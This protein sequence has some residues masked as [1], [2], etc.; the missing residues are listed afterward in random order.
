MAEALLCTI[1]ET[2][3]NSSLDTCR[4]YLILSLTPKRSVNRS[5]PTLQTFPSSF[6]GRWDV[7]NRGSSTF[8]EKPHCQGSRGRLRAHKLLDQQHTPVYFWSPWCLG[9]PAT[10]ALYDLNFCSIE[11]NIQ[12]RLD[13]TVLL[14][15]TMSIFF[16]SRLFHVKE[17]N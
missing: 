8:L 6:T 7:S 14:E 9:T 16:A 2:T 3:P 10:P 17:E 1:S 13:Q 11:G 5:T 12:Q 4:F 15:N